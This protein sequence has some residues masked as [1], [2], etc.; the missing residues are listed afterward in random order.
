MEEGRKNSIAY[1]R[2]FPR[3]RIFICGRINSDEKIVRQKEVESHVRIPE[4]QFL[5]DPHPAF[6]ND[7]FGAE[8]P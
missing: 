1:T 4:Y 6:F 5:L 7:S 2:V 8:L 3:Q